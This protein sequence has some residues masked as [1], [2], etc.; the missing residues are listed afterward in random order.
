[1]RFKIKKKKYK[2]AFVINDIRNFIEC[3]EKWMLYLLTSIERSIIC[4]YYMKLVVMKLT[5]KL[6]SDK[7]LSLKTRQRGTC[8][9]G[10]GITRHQRL[11][12]WVEWL[13]L[14]LSGRGCRWV[15][16][17]R[18]LSFCLKPTKQLFRTEFPLK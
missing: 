14:H 1:M 2:H 10:G 3:V 5:K 16:C 9:C 18:V 12:S 8:G 6:E 7:D 4:L 13:I 15:L 11:I 17:G